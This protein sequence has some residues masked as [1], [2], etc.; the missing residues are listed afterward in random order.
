M[1]F[2]ILVLLLLAYTIWPYTQL[3]RLGQAIDS[4][5][6]HEL[7]RLVDVDA[8]RRQYKQMIDKNIE[9]VG[10]RY[11]NPVFRFV[12]GGV[13]ELSSSALDI[14]DLKWVRETLSATRD[15][16]GGRGSQIL[17]GFSFAFFEAPT[18]FQAR[19]GRLGENPVHLYL[20]MRDWRW[21]VTAVFV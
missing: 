16:P 17:G 5:D 3:Y 1:L 8:I 18:R 21:R 15:Y 20:T 14:V 7:E 19:A 13:K 4:N 10:Q 2:S 9:G 11:D 6:E 12:R